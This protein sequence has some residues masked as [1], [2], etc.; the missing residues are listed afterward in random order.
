MKNATEQL[1]CE[2]VKDRFKEMSQQEGGIA[3][4]YL[5][6]SADDAVKNHRIN[7]KKCHEWILK[8]LQT[9]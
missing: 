9:S 7:C 1:T 6:F 2:Q 8:Q 4:N 5:A 3:G